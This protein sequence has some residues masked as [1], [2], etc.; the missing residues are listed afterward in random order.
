MKIINLFAG[1]GAGKSTTAAGLFHLM[2]LKKYNVELVTEYAKDLTWDERW[3]T[4]SNQLYVFAK[5]YSRIS[6]L[7][8]KVEY[9]VTD[10]PLLL[11]LIYSSPQLH[12]HTF[13]PL[14]L[15]IWKSFENYN[16]FIKRTKEYIKNGRSQ[17]EEEAIEIDKKILSLLQDETYYHV[18]GDHSAP[19]TILKEIK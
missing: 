19:E 1:P 4:L 6:R 17:T 16:F 9:V 5:Q 12:N 15:E 2:K 10:S 11:S 3:S 7:S 13:T 14:V 18:W 8:N